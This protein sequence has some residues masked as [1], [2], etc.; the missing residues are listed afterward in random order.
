MYQ[1]NKGSIWLIYMLPM[2]FKGAYRMHK[3]KKIAES[4]CDVCLWCAELLE[5]EIDF[6]NTNDIGKGNI[7]DS[8]YS[9]TST[10][11]TNVVYKKS[12]RKR[13]W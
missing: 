3:K 8:L 2:Q 12:Y 13:P 10:D 11:S 6:E 4:N 7:N 9:A 5:L 1:P